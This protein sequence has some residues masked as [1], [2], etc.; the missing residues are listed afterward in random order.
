MA[1]LILADLYDALRAADVPDEKATTATAV[2]DFNRRIEHIEAK[3]T[4]MLSLIGVM[5][6]VMLGGFY[7]VWAQLV[8]MSAKLGA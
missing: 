6:A 5:V 2:A 1:K 3:L 4:L 7:A 8:A